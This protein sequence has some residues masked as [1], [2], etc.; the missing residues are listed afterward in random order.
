MP[1]TRM[2]SP[3]SLTLATS[4]RPRSSFIPKT[5]NFPGNSSGK[6][7]KESRSSSIPR[8]LIETKSCSAHSAAPNIDLVPVIALVVVRNGL[9]PVRSSR[10]VRQHLRPGKSPFCGCRRWPYFSCCSL[11]QRWIMPRGAARISFSLCLFVGPRQWGACWAQFGCSTNRWAA[12]SASGT[13]LRFPS[14]H[15]CSCGI[16]ESDI[17]F[18]HRL[19]QT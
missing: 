18:K 17:S 7:P 2:R 16:S 11:F 3:T 13:M 12:S 8:R 1:C 5:R 19:N 6:S 15:S 9:P 14:F 4:L 10:T